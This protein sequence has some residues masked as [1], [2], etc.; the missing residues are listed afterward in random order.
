MTAT[1]EEPAAV[2]AVP[3]WRERLLPLVSGS[4]GW[5]VTL[6]VTVIAGLLRI[7]RLDQP[8]S[9]IDAKGVVT[10]QYRMFDEVYYA[11]DAQN[12]LQHGVERAVYNQ[13]TCH[14]KVPAEGAF[15]VHPPL[16]KWM[17]ALGEQV[18]GINTWG[19]RLSAAVFGTLTVLL[20][21]RIGRRMTGST[22][23]GGMAGLFLALDGLHFVQ[24]RIA[25][26]DVFLCFWVVAA[27]GALVVDR[28]QL[29]HRLSRN[30]EEEVQR[31]GYLG[32]RPWRLVAG[33]CFGAGLATKWSALFPVVVMLV[34]AVCWE[35]GARRTAGIRGPWRITL[36]R[37]SIPLLA[38]LVLV[39]VV[40]Y[41]ASWTGWFM[42]TEGYD[43]LWAAGRSTSFP[44][45]P[46]AM[47]SWWHYHHEAFHFHDTLT[48]T[49][50]YQSHPLSWPFLGRPVSYY[51]P[52]GLKA[53]VYGCQTASCSREV[54]AIGTPALWW[55]MIPAAIGL[56]ARWVSKRDWRASS[57]LLMMAVSI[58]AWEPSDLKNRTMFLFYAL[59]SVPFLCLGLALLCGWLL[60]RAGTVRRTVAAAG[61][62]AYTAL[63]VVNFIYLYPVLAAVTIPYDQWY[64][65][66]WFHS[67]I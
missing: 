50:P 36:R 60:G 19:W 65:R 51:Y 22:L 10:D 57:L 35:V 6:L 12:L 28:D 37:T 53:G 47:R 54:L 26:V 4:G 18:M 43:R 2:V 20:V 27:F 15:V 48:A 49:H 55:A 17:I 3:E 66:M 40:V 67:W 42:S 11:C 30:S 39:P 14:A 31:G 62:G 13:Q 29:R 25:M 16:G 1:L 64:A 46:E 56:A 41:V 63:V 9:S 52:P 33:A 34:L 24:S 32:R 45:I 58:L 21:V 59:P 7:I 38:A 8:V 5:A 61:V 23:L 44:F